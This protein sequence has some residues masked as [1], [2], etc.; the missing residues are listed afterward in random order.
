MRSWPVL[1]AAAALSGCSLAPPYVQPTPPVAAAFP[2]LGDLTFYVGAT[3]AVVVYFATSRLPRLARGK[4]AAA[5][6]AGPARTEMAR[7]EIV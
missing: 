7:T 1:L 6:V 3:I 4:D 2:Q 5:A